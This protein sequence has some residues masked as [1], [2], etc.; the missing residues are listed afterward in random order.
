MAQKL[1]N[2]VLH[3]NGIFFIGS[4]RLIAKASS[5]KIKDQRSFRHFFFPSSKTQTS[6]DKKHVLREKSIASILSHVLL[7]IHTR[8]TGWGAGFPRNFKVMTRKVCFAL[9]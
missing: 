5:K 1:L 4:L 3:D 6:E 7:I 2:V 9:S 8:E